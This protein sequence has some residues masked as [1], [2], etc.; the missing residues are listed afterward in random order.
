MNTTPRGNRVHIA[1]FGRRN[2]GKSSL[3]NAI[4]GQPIALVSDVAG[5]TT[6][7]VYKAMEIL[8]LGPV[9]LIDTAGID[10]EG[11]LGELRVKK[12]LEV[13]DK[14][15]L[16][17]LVMDQQ[18]GF[19]TWEQDLAERIL[20]RKIP[21]LGVVNKIDRA[22]PAASLPGQ[23]KICFPLL[24]VSSLTGQGI[25][26]L[27]ERIAK[28]APNLWDDIPIIGDLIDPG[29]TVVLVVPIDKEAPKGRLILPQVQTIRDILDHGGSALVVQDTG[30]REAL[31][32]LSSPPRLVVTDSQAFAQVASVVPE[33]VPLTSFSILFA[34]HKGDLRTLA[35][36]AKAVAHLP[37]NARILIGEACTHHA[38]GDDIARVKIPNLL[39]KLVGPAVTFTY[40]PGAVFPPM[41]ELEQYDLVIHCGG[42]MI[43]RREMLSR[44]ARVR[45]AG[46]PVINYGVLL[47]YGQG[48]LKRCLQPF[49]L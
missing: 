14:T 10:D 13:L 7:P 12:T 23:N 26:D 9:T 35:D 30:L 20:S 17:L 41:E 21:L 15:D 1:I 5:T 47:A 8:P 27:K 25:W 45:E 37:P 39:K 22:D 44:L 42:C 36:G 38:I 31:R 28:E 32:K 18:T 29:D 34:R 43:N 40:A 11:A 49:G 4:T 6:D 16:A 3:I 19:G 46:V 2:V 48:I 33:S 24:Y